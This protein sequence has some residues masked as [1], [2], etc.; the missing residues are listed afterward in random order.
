MEDAQHVHRAGW[1]PRVMAG[2]HLH[3]QGR[4]IG[5]D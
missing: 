4:L 1:F 5:V 3:R 2:A